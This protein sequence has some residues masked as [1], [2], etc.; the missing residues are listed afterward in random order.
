LI[1][2]VYFGSETVS[3]SATRQISP[4]LQNISQ[5]YLPVRHGEG[6]LII[7]NE[8]LKVEI[9]HRNLNCLSYCNDEGLITS[10]YPLN[11][12]GSELNCAALT[13]STGQI[14]GMMPHPEAYLSIYNNPQW[15][16]LKRED[17]EI[18]EEGEGLKIFQNIVGHIKMKK[19]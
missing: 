3:S 18:S 13:N 9:I 11:P 4:F 14:F 10:D 1:R 8:G 5:I 15:T 16:K 12:N 7:K 17:P 19:G 2:P 6:K